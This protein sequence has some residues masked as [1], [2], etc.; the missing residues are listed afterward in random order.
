MGGDVSHHCVGVVLGLHI[1]LANDNRLF[2][3]RYSCF[4]DDA[5]LRKLSDSMSLAI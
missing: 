1:H 2:W 4:H 5:R 3:S